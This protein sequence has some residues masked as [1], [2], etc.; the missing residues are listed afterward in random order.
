MKKGTMRFISFIMVFILLSAFRGTVYAEEND[1]PKN[2]YNVV[3]VTDESGS[4][5]STDPNGLRYEAILRFVGLAAQTGNYMGSISFSGDIAAEQNVQAV[6]GFGQKENFVNQISSAET[7][8]STNIGLAL[9]RAVDILETSGNPELPSVII[10]L[11]DGN[12][13]MSND[14]QQQE[15]L[16]MKADA[17]E[18]ARQQGYKIYTICLNVDGS[19]DA[20]E[21]QQIASATGGE[22]SEVTTPEDLADVQMMYYKMIFGGIDNGSDNDEITFDENGIAEKSFEVPEVGVEEINIIFE[23]EFTRYEVTNP[24]DYTYQDSELSDMS[25]QGEEF[26]LVK[27]TEPVGGL[28]KAVIYGTPG[29]TINF[30]LLCN[31]AFSI[32]SSI[33]PT[34]GYSIGEKVTFQA[35]IRDVSGIVE[36][37]SKYEDFT[38]K[39][40][41]T[42]G[43]VINEYDMELGEEGFIYEYTIPDEGTYYAS[44]TVSNG[45]ITA[46]SGEPYE[47]SVNNRTPMAPDEEPVAHANIWPIIGGTAILDLKNTATDP[48]GEELTYTIESSAFNEDDYTFD[49]TSLKVN[50]FSIPKGSFTIRATDPHG[51][52][53]TYDVL[54]TSTNI[55]LIMVIAILAGALIVL[56]ILGIIIYKKKFIPFMGTITVEKYDDNS[57]GYVSPVSVTPGRG[58]IRLESFAAGT[59]LPAGCKF[60]A[61]GKDK[62]IY[63][64]SKKPVYSNITSGAVKKITIEG[65]G[66]D[67]RISADPHMEKGI[68]VTFK[69]ILYNQFF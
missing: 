1:V 58:R 10:L 62:N 38:A 47:M 68:I 8:G 5:K 21:M 69:S 37:I 32:E 49:G 25:M 6:E 16:A 52:Y 40:S 50:G 17:I 30:K 57:S 2:R 66:S 46:D 64:R 23:G 43:D 60:Q 61:G 54:V 44:I 67:V 7:V 26:T 27:I 33:S 4:M 12:T 35:Q 48:D 45:E 18:K 34:E 36:D 13:D 24:T 28:W 63:F 15:S 51:A 14:E 41:I 59:G 31:T 19:A 65:S 39:L 22:F 55:G 29:A 20:A 3:F 53:C 11:T 9:Q 42:C 56:I